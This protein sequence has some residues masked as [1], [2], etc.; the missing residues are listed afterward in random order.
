M[1]VA[2]AV[3]ALNSSCHGRHNSGTQRARPACF[4]SSIARACRAA[5]DQTMRVHG[6]LIKWNDDRGFGF[7]AL[8]RSREEIFVH[9]SAFPRDGVR[10][11][12]GEKLSF[13]VRSGPDG[14]KRAEVVARPGSRHDS[15]A[16][17]RNPLK[18]ALTTVVVGALVVAGHSAY[19]SRQG[20]GDEAAH[21]DSQTINSNSQQ[22]KCDG[23][24][25]CSQMTSCEE[26]V[27]FLKHCPGTQMDGDH[28][29]EPCEQQCR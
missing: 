10:P 22:F 5:L 7:V 23:R 24:T 12:I 8:P 17:R 20:V 3:S 15:A 27:Y 6:K 9:V 28:D 2:A 11:R 13:E 16:H 21:G 19:T 18:W 1:I 14:R 29:G 25:K 26:A 4:S